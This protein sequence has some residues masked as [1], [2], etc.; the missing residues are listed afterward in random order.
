MVVLQSM[1]VGF[2]LDAVG[3][4]GGG[5]ASDPVSVHV[6]GY[7]ELVF[8][9]AV[10][11]AL[12]VGSGY[13]NDPCMELAELSFDPDEAV[14]IVFKG[15]DRMDTD[16]KG[17]GLA[18]RETS[19]SGIKTPTSPANPVDFNGD[20]GEGLKTVGPVPEPTAALIGLIGGALL[21][22]RRLR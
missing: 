20:M 17:A 9:A 16:F 15:A 21:I 13:P 7:G 12:V 19:R 4:D 14:G 2:T 8:E 22:L 10:D 11:S 5:L 18:V 6:A 1:A 3:Y